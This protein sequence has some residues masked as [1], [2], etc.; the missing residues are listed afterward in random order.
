MAGD[1]QP[2][3]T[4]GSGGAPAQ[5]G[6][7]ATACTAFQ[8]P[9]HPA[10][11]QELELQARYISALDALA[12]PP[13]A[14]GLL[15]T[16]AGGGALPPPD[17]APP[18]SAGAG[19]G[20]EAGPRRLGLGLGAAASMEAFDARLRRIAAERFGQSEA[21]QVRR[22][23][24]WQKRATGAGADGGQSPASSC[25]GLHCRRSAL[26][27]AR[28]PHLYTAAQPNLGPNPTPLTNPGPRTSDARVPAA[29]PA[30][31]PVTRMPPA[32]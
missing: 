19:P 20:A 29:G 28:P 7:R 26:A 31:G 32:P 5:T 8:K 2:C 24:G 9:P 12:P 27:A 3:N 10:V 13:P 22:Q 30:A 16:S 4:P 17:R 14:I 18:P 11:R 6:S 15:E 25:L 23:E 1:K 21:A